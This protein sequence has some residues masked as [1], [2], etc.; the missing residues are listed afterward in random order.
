MRAADGALLLALDEL[1]EAD[2]EH[3]R[4][5]LQECEALAVAKFTKIGRERFG[6]LLRLVSATV[7]FVPERRREALLLLAAGDV[8]RERFSARHRGKHAAF[9]PR[10]LE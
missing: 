3:P 1:V 8:A 7:K 6:A 5:E 9:R 4:D 10:P 2:A